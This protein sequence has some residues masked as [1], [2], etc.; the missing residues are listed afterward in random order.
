MKREEQNTIAIVLSCSDTYFP[1]CSLT[2]QS[3]I[4]HAAPER[5][6]DIVVFSF[7]VTKQH[8]KMLKKL[9]D[10]YGYISVRFVE[11]GPYISSYHLY[12]RNYYHPVI[13]ARLCLPEIMKDYTKV[14]YLDSDLMVLCDLAELFDQD[15]GNSLIAGVCDTGMLAWYHTPEHIEQIYIDEY[16]HLNYPDEYINTG[17]MVFNVREIRKRYSTAFLMEYASSRN[18]RWQDQDVFMTLF[19]GKIFLLD[20]AWNVLVYTGENDEKKIMAKLPKELRQAYHFAWYHPKVVHFIGNSFLDIRH[21]T[22]RK[23]IFWEYAR[24][25]PFYEM[26]LER[27]L[28]YANENKGSLHRMG[29]I[30]Q[31]R[32]KLHQPIRILFDVLFPKKSKYRKTIK[33]LYYYCRYFRK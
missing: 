33:N 20:F 6:Y 12:T 21:E 10:S 15:I 23:R 11:V 7:E 4:A 30:D 24:K 22:D 9:A 14:I 29:V 27:A 17:V 31:I 16:L 2:V 8:Q 18:W 19:E 26:I 5:K 13:Y 1:Y 28:S 32:K 25:S 3:V